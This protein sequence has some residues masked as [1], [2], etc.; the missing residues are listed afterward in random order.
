MAGGVILPPGGLGGGHCR[1]VVVA[2]SG[3][4]QSIVAAGIGPP[5]GTATFP[6]SPVDSVAGF[7]PNFVNLFL[8]LLLNDGWAIVSY[9]YPEAAAPMFGYPLNG[10]GGNGSSNTPAPS[11]ALWRDISTDTGFGKRYLTT[12]TQ[13]YK[14]V[15]DFC[16]GLLNPV[17]GGVVNYAKPVP[18]V[19]WGFSWGGYHALQFAAQMWQYIVG[20]AAHCPATVLSWTGS[21]NND[22]VYNPSFNGTNTSGLDLHQHSLDDLG[23]SWLTGDLIPGMA[24]YGTSDDAVGWGIPG[25]G[26]APL[27]TYG[28][29]PFSNLDLMIVNALAAGQP[30]MRNQT[31]DNHVYTWSDAGSFYTTTGPTA[32]SSFTGTQT[33]PV[34]NDT[35]ENM[36]NQMVSGQTAVLGSDGVWHEFTFGGTSGG[37]EFTDVTVLSPGSATISLGAPVCGT[38]NGLAGGN[39]F[40][41]FYW[42]STNM[43]PIC[44]KQY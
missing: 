21:V 14:H 33:L 1:G 22:W 11:Q 31:N 17:V 41:E 39:P 23:T 7:L 13:M 42:F 28:S 12:T 44:P 30:I 9:T 15:V 5:S 27:E 24:T 37:V 6:G 43:D 38:G 16:N 4:Q 25:E 3:L 34:Y 26:T 36:P 19:P 40:S 2:G 20:Y 29:H 10:K 18:I 8:Q 35:G 32:L